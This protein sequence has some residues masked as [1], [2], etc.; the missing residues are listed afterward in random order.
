MKLYVLS[1]TAALFAVAS[2]AF[3]EATRVPLGAPPVIAVS[4]PSAADEADR[5][6][7]NATIT[8]TGD[9]IRLG[10]I[11]TGYL[12]RPEKVVAEAPAPGQRAVL[13]AE[14]LEKL[15]RTYG[16]GW[17][18]TGA[19]DRA[20]VY[21]PGQIVAQDAMIEA[22]RAD[23]VA[24]GLPA[25]FDVMPLAPVPA[26]TVSMAAS[27]AVGVREAYFDPNTKN[28][29]A[30]V[31]IPAGDPK[32][33]FIP[34]RGVAF[35]TAVVPVLKENAGKTQ[36]I[37]AAMIDMVKV[38]AELVKATTI[39]DPAA[40][41]GKTPKYLVKAGLPVSENDVALVRM[42]DVPVLRMIATREDKLT[43]DQIVM[44]TVN[45]ADLPAGAVLD[46]DQLLGKTPRRTLPAGAPIQ[47]HDVVMVRKVTVPALARDINR[48][49]ILT[50]ADL[51]TTTI[52]EAQLVNNVLVGVE[53]IIG[54]IAQQN[55][56]SGQLVHSFNI[57]R[58]IAVERGK[59]V[60][61]IYAAPMMNLTA[62]GVAQ[63]QGG[64]GDAIRVVNAKSN[65]TLV[66]EVIDARTVRIGS[67]EGAK[68]TQNPAAAGG[69]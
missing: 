35:A 59:M 41:I 40:L 66:A 14:W 43:K 64:V 21:Q 13:S 29:S 1:A 27:T 32:A 20:T 62:Q 65:T 57:A 3:G 31:E 52:T 67:K 53:A 63:E 69:N 47:A 15:S 6:R 49:E 37:T 30:V 68:Q 45:A 38:R 22:V 36:A 2:P 16:L 25:S 50:A 10:D 46:I 33:T 42:I 60:T 9:V 58:P 44:T 55:L 17:R 8:V 19:Y 26:V 56:R 4:E 5:V 34:M 28:F 12:A 39:T 54:R 51:T 24:R 61:I 7:L 11:F 18:A 48:G 23:L